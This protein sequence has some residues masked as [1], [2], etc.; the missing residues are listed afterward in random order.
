MVLPLKN[1]HCQISHG[2]IKFLIFY[3]F[4]HSVSMLWSW[5]YHSLIFYLFLLFLRA[6]ISFFINTPTFICPTLSFYIFTFISQK[7]RSS[8]TSL[9]VDKNCNPLFSSLHHI[10]ILFPFHLLSSHRIT[11][12][13]DERWRQPKITESAKQNKKR[14]QQGRMDHPL[15]HLESA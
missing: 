5:F 2:F 11:A 8:S 10:T 15:E 12:S 1:I 13:E 3:L 7:A 4:F 9:H 6:I 14:R